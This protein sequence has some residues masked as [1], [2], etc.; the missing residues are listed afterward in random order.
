MDLLFYSTIFVICSSILSVLVYC[1][2]QL[3]LSLWYHG[4]S[5]DESKVGAKSDK[6]IQSRRYTK[7]NHMQYCVGPR[8]SS[9]TKTLTL[10]RHCV[11][12]RMPNICRVCLHLNREDGHQSDTS[13]SL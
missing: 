11:Q 5:Q 9:T 1:S 2:M 13:N 10:A 12:S 3:I 7:N 6:H 8:L 4:Q